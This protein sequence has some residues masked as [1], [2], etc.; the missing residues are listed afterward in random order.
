MYPASLFSSA[1]F[2]I[3]RKAVEDAGGEMMM[4]VRENQTNE[5][6]DEKR[7]ANSSVKGIG[8]MAPCCQ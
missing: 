3:L 6:N 2:D 5:R 8:G 7:K 4:M 1:P